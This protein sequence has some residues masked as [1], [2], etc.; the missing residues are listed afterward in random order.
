MKPVQD[1]PARVRRRFREE[2]AKRIRTHTARAGNP[3]AMISFTFDDVP[4]SAATEGAAVLERYGARGTFYVAGALCGTRGEDY[5]HLSAEGCLALDGA[6]HEIA[7]HTFS[8]RHVAD[9]S[10]AELADEIAR[11]AGFFERLG[12]IRLTNFSYPFGSVSL[13]RKRQLGS[14]FA[15]CRSTMS[16]LNGPALDLGYLRAVVLWHGIGRDA[17]QH[18]IDRAVR[19]NAWLIFVAHDVTADHAPW[20]CTPE[21]FLD[22]V[23]R[24]A[25][26][27]AEILTVRDALAFAGV[28]EPA[29]RASAAVPV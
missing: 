15:S 4:V 6:G 12:G 5:P 27:S 24:A 13:A 2:A 18:W 20:G 14:V 17:V 21:H 29:A 1:L 25:A 16:G 22:V 7:C 28:S 10:A 23:R 8:H 19:E 26:S 11:N 3:R 9:A